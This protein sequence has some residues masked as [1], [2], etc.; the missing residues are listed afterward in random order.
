MR[1]KGCLKDERF[2]KEK[3][4]QATTILPKSARG[5]GLERESEKGILKQKIV[6]CLLKAALSSIRH[7]VNIRIGQDS[8]SW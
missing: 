2:S 6:F 4:A 3:R 1:L 8:S 7:F 5:V